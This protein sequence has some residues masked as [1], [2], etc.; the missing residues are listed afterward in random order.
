V[1][2]IGTQSAQTRATSPGTVILGSLAPH[3]GGLDRERAW[4]RK[5]W[6]W[7]AGCRFHLCPFVIA[8]SSTKGGHVQYLALIYGDEAAWET[9]DESEREDMMR[10]YG[11]FAGKAHAAGVMAGGDELAPTHDA[12]TVRVRNAQTLVVDG[13]YAEVKEALAGFFVFECESIDEA[14]DWA[15]GIPGARHGAIE[16]RPVHR[17]PEEAQL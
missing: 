6:D 11:D 16:V 17:D 10:G 15:A 14:C 13:P 7:I 5:L 4:A 9:L 2:N 8:V 1:T 12:T 3:C